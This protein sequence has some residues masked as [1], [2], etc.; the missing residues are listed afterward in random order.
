MGWWS[1]LWK[2]KIWNAPK[3]TLFEYQHDTIGGKFHN[4]KLFHEQNW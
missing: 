3:S 4:L 1:L 2:L